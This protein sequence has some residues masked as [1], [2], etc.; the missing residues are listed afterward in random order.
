MSV[1]HYKLRHVMTTLIVRSSTAALYVYVDLAMSRIRTIPPCVMVSAWSVVSKFLHIHLCK[2]LLVFYIN[3]TPQDNVTLNY[4][5]QYV[6]D[7]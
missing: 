1:V 2:C 6:T 5:R 4:N 3:E 7:H